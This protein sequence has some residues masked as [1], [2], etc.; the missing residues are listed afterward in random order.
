MTDI[1]KRHFCKSV[2]LMSLIPLFKMNILSANTSAQNQI[3]SGSFLIDGKEASS[4][5]QDL[6]KT[7]I[8]TKKEKTIIKNNDDFY[9][10]RPE[11]KI[12]FVSKKL[13]NVIEG[14]VHAVFG[15]RKEELKV[16]VPNGTIGIRGTSIFIDIEP[17][18]N[19]TYFCN[20]YGKTTLFDND[21]NMLDDIT[22]F[23]HESGAI[24]SDGKFKRYGINYLS[25]LY[26]LRHPKIFDEEME[27]AGCIVK[28]SHCTLK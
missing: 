10:I 22:S 15:K 27:K 23:G 28:N 4:N 3:L 9:L 12:E 26:A 16:K 5:F 21:G 7:V 18:D 20:C 17:E 14:S 25:N 11:T 6:N 13:L 8:E 2:A 19:R 1:K 24:T